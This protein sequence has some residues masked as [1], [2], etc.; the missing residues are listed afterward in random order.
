VLIRHNEESHSLVKRLNGGIILHQN[1][2]F[3][4]LNEQLK[5]V[6]HPEEDPTL[7]W[8]REGE[9]IIDALKLL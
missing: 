7:Y 5:N 9:G 4:K 6:N 3:E 1:I 8:D 2:N